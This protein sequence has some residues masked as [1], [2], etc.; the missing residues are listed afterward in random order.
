[1]LKR[2]TGFFT[3]WVILVLNVHSAQAQFGLAIKHVFDYEDIPS[4]EP[5]RSNDRLL[6]HGGQLALD[7]RIK[8]VNYGIVFG[9]ELIAKM[10]R[11][12]DVPLFDNNSLPT[13]SV[14]NIRSLGIN[15]P[16]TIYP[17][18]FDQCDEC[19]SF[20]RQ[21]FFQ[22]NFFIQP[23]VG[24]EARNWVTDPAEVTETIN[25]HFVIAGF[26]IGADIKAGKIVR[27]SPIVQYKY[28]FALN[29]NAHYHSRLKPSMLE[30][31]IRIGWGR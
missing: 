5:G 4:V 17:F 24:Y 16:V 21:H 23:V 30:A 8:V 7:Y 22:N 18:H 2:L 27:F 26:G 19:P 12:K 3:F 1:M 9:P 31:G 20:K 6:Q 11:V 10:V 15:I 28:N 29:E 13:G 14:K 25:E